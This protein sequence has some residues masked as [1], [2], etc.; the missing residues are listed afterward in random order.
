MVI[1]VGGIIITTLYNVAEVAC[2]SMQLRLRCSTC[3][4]NTE[5]FLYGKEHNKNTGTRREVLTFLFLFLRRL[6]FGFN[7]RL[8]LRLL[9]FRL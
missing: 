5:A 1:M 2:R 9:G 6:S 4:N 8:L 3:S 7:F